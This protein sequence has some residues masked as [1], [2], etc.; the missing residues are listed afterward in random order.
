MSPR[1]PLPAQRLAGRLAGRLA[2]CMVT[3]LVAAWAMMAP[4]G[5]SGPPAPAAA[6]PAAQA[7]QAPSSA[8]RVFLPVAMRAW[9]MDTT[10]IGDPGAPGLGNPGYDIERYDVILKFAID[11]GADG[12]PARVDYS[13]ITY[14][15]GYA[16][17]NNLD[18]IALDFVL[19][20]G[21]IDVL[22]DDSPVRWWA[23]PGNKIW[24]APQPALP[25]GTP[26]KL[27]FLYGGS[28]RPNGAGFNLR[29]GGQNVLQAWSTIGSASSW[30]P[31]NNHPR[32]RAQFNFTLTAPDPYVPVAN[33]TL[34]S[35]F[36]DGN[37]STYV[38]AVRRQMAVGDAMV[39][40]APYTVSESA[41]ASGVPISRYL[42]RTPEQAQPALEAV[43]RQLEWFSARLISY[44]FERLSIVE[45][46][47]NN[48]ASLAGLVVLGRNQAGNRMAYWDR[49]ASLMARQWFGAAVGV[50]NRGD[51]WLN[52]GLATYL[53]YLY[54]ARDQGPE[55]VRARLA[56][57]EWSYDFNVADDVALIDLPADG[58][59]GVVAA[60]K[61]PFAFHRLRLALG[62]TAFWAALRKYLETTPQL[63]ASLDALDAVAIDAA[64]LT[65]PTA[66]MRAELAT[67]FRKAATPRLN[68]AWS[69]SGGAKARVCQLTATPQ[70]FTLPLQLY[71]SAGAK[72]A[73]LTI[74]QA[75]QVL[76]IPYD[77]IL[78]AITPDP[79]QTM[80]A[81]ILMHPLDDAPLPACDALPM[82]AL[83]TGGA[84]AAVDGRGIDLDNSGG[85]ILDG[86][87]DG[88]IDA[89]IDAGIDGDV[90]VDGSAASGVVRVDTDDD[91]AGI[92]MSERAA[93]ARRHLPPSL[94]SPAG[95]EARPLAEAAASSRRRTTS[96]SAGLA[97][98]LGL[99]PRSTSSLPGE[100]S[101][102]DPYLPYLGNTG[103]DVITYTVKARIDPP[104]GRLEADTTIQARATIS[105]LN[106]L[107]LDFMRMAQDKGLDVS[108][109]D[110]DGQAAT[111][112]RPA[113]A[114]KLW[115]DLPQ[116]L[117]EGQPFSVRVVYAGVP[118]AG[119]QDV[120]S[121]GL[122]SHGQGTMYAIS[123][124][125][126][127]R[128]W[129]PSNDHPR[130]KAAF[131]FE[132]T[133]PAP[134]VAAANG[135]LIEERP[136]DTSTTWVFEMRQPMSTYLATV[137][138]GRFRTADQDGPGGVKIRHYFLN[139][140][141]TAMRVADVT[142]DVLRV[143]GRL[144]APYAFDTYG[145]YAAPDF[146]G[147]MENQTLTAIGANVFTS[148]APRGLHSLIAHEA[149][150]Q[151]FGDALSP[152]TW[153]DIWLNEGFATYFAEL[154]RA[155]RFGP[156]PLGWRMEAL[157]Y[158]VLAGGADA[159]VSQPILADMFGTNTYEKGGWVLN[160]LR[161]QLGDAA[162]FGGLTAY[163][164]A[165]RYGNVRTD[166]LRAALE[167]ASGKDLAAFFDQWV[168]RAGNPVVYAG[169]FANSSSVHV[170]LCQAG[171]PFDLPIT[172]A[173]SG[174]GHAKRIAAQLSGAET[175]VD[176]STDFVADGVSI[177]PDF[178]LLA[179]VR[180]AKVAANDA[181]ASCN[182]IAAVWAAGV[183]AP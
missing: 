88:G 44:P 148:R 137:A 58:S 105:A 162:F 160:M 127:T 14:L 180:V 73:S 77:G 125:D 143:Y 101:I 155:D 181:D 5:P 50:Q 13:A 52:S 115:V 35:Q 54:A 91:G 116:P 94:R 118:R 18:R 20:T 132:I 182:G 130:D 84:G 108:S 57:N 49:N 154:W 62:D 4:A 164:N 72:S 37:D 36:R 23:G 81:D 177:D 126:G 33:G 179:D 145:H 39:N 63:N 67:S 7:T 103:Y 24:I 32:D 146:G 113:D 134:F 30:F 104:A 70:S 156:E 96:P 45:S 26:F 174:A 25:I 98:R 121:G 151:W 11:P 86:G 149:A 38:Y 114:D 124:P 76:D 128:N 61:T 8:Q 89:G 122:L 176:I 119:G 92:G 48:S 153:A 169:W 110:V 55:I 82:P 183:G 41:T 83:A 42:L 163:F 99:A 150:H 10:S 100:P 1:H 165:H 131:R 40:I 175:D 53:G 64:A 29:G 43:T 78:T 170:R 123:E 157:R 27:R 80:L 159:P 56:A 16:A 21:P 117:A 178:E 171:A 66:A 161:S 68:L 135:V 111:F 172:V 74:T 147:G 47:T 71:G 106:R 15:Y 112:D 69:R 2:A 133:A 34:A 79:E 138:V 139:D 85:S 59:Q 9:A 19:P 140:P 95:G 6:A 87:I 93:D 141:A 28:A 17:E 142:P 167:A 75:D 109:V 152:Y 102:G 46:G 31:C 129:I 136:G 158:T 12:T 97:P 120:F 90:D 51:D 173:A 65:G 22:L 168:H 144:V 107:S 60:N 3:A 166:D